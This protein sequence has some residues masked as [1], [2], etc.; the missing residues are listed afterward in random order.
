MSS[1]I[2]DSARMQYLKEMI[3]QIEDECVPLFKN[4]R[5]LQEE[6]YATIDNYEK[7]AKQTG[8][9]DEIHKMKHAREEQ[10]KKV[11]RCCL[12]IK[13]KQTKMDATGKKYKIEHLRNR[14]ETIDRSEKNKIKTKKESESILQK[15]QN[16]PSEIVQIIWSYL[17]NDVK[18]IL[19]DIQ[20]K[21]IL[22]SRINHEVKNGLLTMMVRSVS[23]LLIV[24][25]HVAKLQINDSLDSEPYDAE[26]YKCAII[27][28]K[29]RDVIQM[30]KEKDPNFAYQ[31]LRKSLM[32]I[33]PN[34]KYKLNLAALKQ[35]PPLKNTDY[36]QYTKERRKLRIN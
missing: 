9:P 19:L 14:V 24:P 5:T 8:N 23:F 36:I 1:I 26:I 33:K 15:V 21:S 3:Y 7:I 35:I 17:P 30:A 4:L 28:L 25:I 16:M 11:Q 10:T 20:F 34:K 29:L 12:E 22:N 27:N 32:L 18:N 13:K 31:I 2:K 6:L